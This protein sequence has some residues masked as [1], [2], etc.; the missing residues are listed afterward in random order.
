MNRWQICEQLKYLL[1]KR[2]WEDDSG[3]EKVFNAFTTGGV[4]RSAWADIPTPFCIIQPKTGKADPEDP[5]LW[6]YRF[7]FVI[8]AEV[9]GDSLG[10]FA[11]MGGA[12]TGGQGSSD[13]R[14]LLELEEELFKA[15]NLLS[16]DL[17]I[18]YQAKNADI[19]DSINDAEL[20]YMALG[21]YNYD[22]RGASFRYY[23]PVTR[24]LGVD[25]TGGNCTLTWQLPPD[26]YDRRSIIVR[27][28][29]GSTAPATPSAGTGISLSSDLATSKT[30]NPGAGV[31]SYAV[32]AAYLE[33]SD[34]K[35]P[36]S[37]TPDR[38]S[39]A[40]TVTVTVT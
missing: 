27:R 17:G 36:T 32:F 12:R 37:G 39:L 10:E 40:A 20:G 15:L 7:K 16:T 31:F 14:G 30:D 9:E 38:Y 34:E 23:H 22:I 2:K 13:G 24:L 29:A 26:R 19:E 18:E 1:R 28:A 35:P 6:D 33:N 25:A 8:I 3:N 21:T 4:P 11:M 5:N